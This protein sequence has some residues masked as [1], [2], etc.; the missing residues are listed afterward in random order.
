[1]LSGVGPVEHLK[2]VGVPVVKDLPGV[3]SHLKDH[4]VVDLNYLDKSRT[5]LSFMRPSTLGQRLQ[6]TKAVLQYLMFKTGPLTTNV[7]RHCAILSSVIAYNNF[8]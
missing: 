2:A 5:S 8:F 6:L 3:G 7:S 4:A 1:M